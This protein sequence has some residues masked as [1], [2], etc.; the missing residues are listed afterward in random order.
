MDNTKLSST[1]RL[2][3][4]QAKLYP[5]TIDH[6]ILR[7]ID[8]PPNLWTET[9]S[10]HIVVGQ[11]V[12][13][14]HIHD[15]LNQILPPANAFD[16]PSEDDIKLLNQAM[17]AYNR[18]DPTTIDLLTKVLM[19]WKDQPSDELAALYRLRADAQMRSGNA[20]LAKLDY[21]QAID[22]LTTTPAGRDNAD[23]NELP[24]AYLGRARAAR[25]MT[26]GASTN[27]PISSRLELSMAAAKD[28]QMSL[29]LSSREE[30]DTNEELEEDGA[31]R[32]PY[33]A[34]EWGMSLRQ[35]ENYIDATRVHVMASQAFEDIGD[36]ARSVLS[37]LDAGID[38]AAATASTTATSITTSDTID[39]LTKAIDRTIKVESRDV[40]LLQRLLAKEGEARMALASI[41]WSTP[42]KLADGEAQYGQA[43]LR[44]EQLEQDAMTRG[45]K[46]LVPTESYPTLKYS[47]DDQPGALDISCSRFKND[48]FL[49]ETLQWPMSLQ[50]KVKK[51]NHLE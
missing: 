23:P 27:V 42:G 7:T 6:S 13:Q 38:M 47:I 12:I 31:A 51:L 3:I 41:L 20:N 43:C 9:G 46:T 10:S 17:D 48:K 19:L 32:N 28:Y 4:T 11:H 25:S 1:Y 30:W 45:T 18:K 35:A 39:L 49:E 5:G 21:S 26:T 14:S 15:W 36:K 16:V 50:Q 29:R 34:W 24:T 37:L 8:N 40:N 22:L 44:L 2:K 33:A